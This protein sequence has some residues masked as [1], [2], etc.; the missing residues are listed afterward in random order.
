[1][2]ICLFGLTE[3]KA[4]IIDFG[5]EFTVDYYIKESVSIHDS[6][7]ASPTVVNLIDPGVITAVKV[8][9]HS[10]LNMFGGNVWYWIEGYENSKIYIGGGSTANDGIEVF[11]NCEAI[12]DGTDFNYSL[13]YLPPMGNLTGKLA[14]GHSLDMNFY[15]HDQASIQLVPEPAT[16]LL[17]GLGCLVIRRA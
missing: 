11:G 3:S 1:M 4:L 14:D 9:G 8:H 13:G 15:I 6:R 7:R 17:L 10:E 12:I 5:G 2:L 16:L